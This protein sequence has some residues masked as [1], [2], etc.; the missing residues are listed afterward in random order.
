MENKWQSD[1]VHTAGEQSKVYLLYEKNSV[2]RTEMG[3]SSSNIQRTA[4][5]ELHNLFS[6]L[7]II[8]YDRGGVCDKHA[9]DWKIITIF[10]W[11]GELKE[12]GLFSG[13]STNVRI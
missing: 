2:I 7:Y 3:S 10:L 1:I 5:R 8:L 13:V 9:K 4:Q 12:N 6:S 11:W